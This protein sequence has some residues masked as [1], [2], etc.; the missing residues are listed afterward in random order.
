V[1]QN[2]RWGRTYECFSDSPEL[3]SELGGAAVRGYQQSNLA[4]PGSVLACAKHY[5]GDGGTSNGVDQGNTECDEATL[6]RIHLPPYEAAVKAGVGSVMAS[7]SSWN[8]KKLHGHKFLLTDL[9]KG[10]LGF[11]GFVVSDWAAIDQ[12]TKDY[13][14]AIELSINAGIDMVMIPNGPGTPNNYVE[15]ITSLKQLV[16]EGKVPQARV[17][18]AVRRILRVKLRMGLFERPL[19]DSA[20]LAKIGAPE[21]RQVARA[22]VRSSLVLL[23]NQNQVLP[24]SK[25]AKHIHV[26]GKAADDLGT[27]CGGWTISWQGETGKVTPGISLGR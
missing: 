15:F 4:K 18:D 26:V 19:T 13:R 14:S 5:L 6:R 7:Y 23:K 22:C 10:E 25:K 1:A 8:G 21:H 27:Q 20:L 12:L 11:D 17:D 2:P 16:Q 24:L 3:V 9:L